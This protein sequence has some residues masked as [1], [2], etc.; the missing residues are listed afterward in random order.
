MKLKLRFAWTADRSYGRVYV[1]TD[2]HPER[3][4][5]MWHF[6]GSYYGSQFH[7]MSYARALF[8]DCDYV[9]VVSFGE[10]TPEQ[11]LAERKSAKV[12]KKYVRLR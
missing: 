1:Y 6:S 11:E 8:M 2:L 9:D 4:V 5:P 12:E 3:D 7:V 10:S